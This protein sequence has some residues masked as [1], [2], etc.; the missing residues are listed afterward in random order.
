[1]AGAETDL[2][3]RMRSGDAGA[4]RE[5]YTQ[6]AATVFGAAARMVDAAR[7]EDIVQDVFLT[8]WKN[9][10]AFDPERGELRA[11]LVTAA[12]NRARNELRRT[13]SDVDAPPDDIADDAAAPDEAQWAEHR[14]AVVRKALEAL[15]PAERRALSLAF[16]EDLTQAEVAAVL[17]TPLGTTKTR[18]RSALKRLAP[19]LLAAAVVGVVVVVYRRAEQRERA[20]EMVTSSDVIPRRLDAA[21]GIA[22]EAHAQYRARPGATTAVLTT[23]KLPPL[24]PGEHYAAWSRTGETWTLLGT[25]SPGEEQRALRIAESPLLATPPTELRVTRETATTQTPQGPTIL[26]WE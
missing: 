10:T 21:P 11:W 8:L 2:V 16:M 5:V 19:I 6:Y 7:A 18:I 4:L 22:P 14:R 17:G 23:T 24:A 3:T 25:I 1:M 15:P 13:R 20:L 12:K 26:K 9:P